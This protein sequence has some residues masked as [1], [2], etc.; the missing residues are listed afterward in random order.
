MPNYTISVIFH[1]V[2]ILKNSHPLHVRFY[3]HPVSA[4]GKK[5]KVDRSFAKNAGFHGRALEMIGFM[6]VD[7]NEISDML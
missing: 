1:H 4:E 2:H 7:L 6:P 5:I 3:H